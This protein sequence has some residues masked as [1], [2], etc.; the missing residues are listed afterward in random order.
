M[1]SPVPPEIRKFLPLIALGLFFVLALAI[2]TLNRDWHPDALVERGRA[3]S[4]DVVQWG[5]PVRAFALRY[6]GKPDL[7]VPQVSTQGG[8]LTSYAVLATREGVPIAEEG[9]K[10]PAT[11]L[12]IHP[13]Y[14]LMGHF[15]FL[16]WL[17]PNVESFEF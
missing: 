2:P 15:Q 16:R 7:F 14:V 13:E 17:L 1:V 11:G 6:D 4:W 9:T 10:L 5:R 8:P 3:V 12:R